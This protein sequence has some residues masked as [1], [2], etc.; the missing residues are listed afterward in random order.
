MRA[1][2][3]LTAVV[4]AGVAQ[5]EFR[6]C[7][8]GTV[9]RALAVAWHDGR[10]WVAE[11]WWRVDPGAC[12]RPITGDLTQRH[13]YLHASA[14]GADFTRGAYPFC[15][16]DQA[17]AL[18]DA[19]LDC[20]AGAYP[21][22]FQHVDTGQDLAF[23][24]RVDDG[25]LSGPAAPAPQA[26]VDTATPFAPGTLGDPFTVTALAQVCEATACRL[27]AEGWVWWLDAEAN[28]PAILAWLAAQPLLT[29]VLVRGDITGQGDITVEVVARRV[30][31]A[32]PDDLAAIRQAMQGAWTD[33]TDPSAELAITGSEEV[34]SY[35]GEAL[36]TSL[37]TW[38]TQGCPDG[39]LP[40]Q[41]VLVRQP[42]GQPPEQALCLAVIAAAPDRMVL[43]L[44]A[45]GQ[46]LTYVRP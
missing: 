29:P 39:S 46:D 19:D 36:E 9:P 6:V 33:D 11:G 16:R 3:I 42:Y 41:T 18:T 15:V 30:D 37:L 1:I 27:V 34:L 5:A 17:F 22:D 45:R 40:G 13:I 24:V 10:A 21:L 32:E 44:P 8:D 25:S 20:P 12:A 23:T 31:P 38:T 43:S 2:A 4:W 7:N 14:E 28:D 35:N 26:G